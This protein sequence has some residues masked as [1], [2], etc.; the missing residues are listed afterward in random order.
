VAQKGSK[1]LFG[2]LPAGDIYVPFWQ[3]FCFQQII[4]RVVVEKLPSGVLF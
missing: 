3:V 2:N 4:W 1:L